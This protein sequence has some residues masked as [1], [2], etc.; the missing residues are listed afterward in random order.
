VQ[1]AQ[2]AFDRTY[3]RQTGLEAAGRGATLEQATRLREL[4]DL[5]RENKISERLA[6]LKAGG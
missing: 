6:A 5:A 3:Q 1:A 2:S 4:N